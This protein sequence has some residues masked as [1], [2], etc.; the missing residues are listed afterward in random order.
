MEKILSQNNYRPEMDKYLHEVGSSSD[1]RNGM[2]PNRSKILVMAVL[3]GILILSSFPM[4]LVTADPSDPTSQL[5]SQTLPPVKYAEVNGVTFGYREYGAGEPLLLICGFGATMDQWNA[6]FVSLLAAYYHVFVYDHRGMGYSS[7]N[8][9]MHT[10]A[11]YANDAVGLMHALGY[12]NMNTYGTSMGSSISQQLVIDH[13]EAI[14]KMILSSATY[15][16]MIPEC[17]TLLGLIESIASN[18]SY[19]LGIREEASANLI[20]DGSWD[21]LAGINKSVMLIVGTKDILTPDSVSVQIADQINGSWVVR[22]AGIPHSGQSYAPVQYANSIIY[23]LQTNETPVFSPIPPLAP[24][25]LMAVPGGG[26]ICLSWNAPASDGGSGIAGYILYR[27]LQPIAYL[28][29][30]TLSYTDSG[31]AS[32]TEYTYYVVAVNAAG[33]SAISTLVCSTPES[34]NHDA[35]YILIG[36]CGTAVVVVVLMAIVRAKR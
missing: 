6:T 20:W 3:T 32:G 30:T 21:Y 34:Q 35:L 36:T 7:D 16:I 19:S 23:F 28:N 2:S 24:S 26:Q 25:G 33:S 14:R 31:L 1:K 5:S 29:A 13:P 9:E 17:G 22:L 4:G 15:S 12:Q 8:N 18:E 27:G 10:M 11:M